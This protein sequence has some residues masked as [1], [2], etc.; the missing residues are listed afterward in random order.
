MTTGQAWVRRAVLLTAALVL[1]TPDA[2]GLGA[3]ALLLCESL[4]AT[5]QAIA[6]RKRS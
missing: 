4:T 5:S 6:A 1:L 2:I 3:I